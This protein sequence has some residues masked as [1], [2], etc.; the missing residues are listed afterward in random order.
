MRTMIIGLAA[1][2]VLAAC[3]GDQTDGTAAD[4]A[5]AAGDTSTALAP[6][7]EV[8]EP[9]VSSARAVLRNGEGAEVGT[10]TFTQAGD[11]VRIEYELTSLPAGE[12]GFHLHQMGSCEAPSFESAG[13]HFNPDNRSH[14]F[15]HPQGPHAGDL[16]NITIGEAGDTLTGDYMNDRVTLAEGAPNSL[17]DAD[18]TALVVHADPDDNESQ[19]SGNAGARIA[20]GVIERG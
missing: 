1:A 10:A 11:G 15:D 6:A 5:M 3:G 2:G 17:F 13:G 12:H 20:C 8:S 19:P 14:G 7:P 4:G 16:P 9:T 18:G